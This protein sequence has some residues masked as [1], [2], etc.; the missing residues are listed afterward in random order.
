LAQFFVY[1]INKTVL[2]SDVA[3]EDSKH[4]RPK[5]SIEPTK[6]SSKELRKQFSWAYQSLGFL[7]GEGSKHSDDTVR[8]DRPKTSIFTPLTLSFSATRTSSIL[9]FA[10]LETRKVV[11]W[12]TF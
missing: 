11:I 6:K 3:G 2:L 9:W 12:N 8:E 5:P 7:G 10:R 1:I 4:S